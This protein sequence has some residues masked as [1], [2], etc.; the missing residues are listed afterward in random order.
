[1][2]LFKDK[3]TF[4]AK[5]QKAWRNWL[6]KNHAKEQNVWLIIYLKASAT[7]SVYYTES[8]D[9]AICFG[10]IDSV[11]YKRDEESRY[12]FYSRRKLKSGWSKVNKEKI[13]RLTELGLMTEA[14]LAVIE[15]AKKDGSWEKLDLVEQ[16]IIPDDLQKLFAKNKKAKTHFDAF[17]RSAKRTI[18][19]WINNAK[20]E[21]TRQKRIEETVRLAAE[22]KKANDQTQKYK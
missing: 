1:M 21:E 17:S 2:E 4:Y 8:V 16:L 3:K 14:G 6:M 11:S 9:E 19:E 12:Q 22:N 5:D 20:R 13:I 10:W 18:L 15:Q 7:P